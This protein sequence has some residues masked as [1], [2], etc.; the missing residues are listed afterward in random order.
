MGAGARGAEGMSDEVLQRCTTC[1]A[2]LTLDHLRGT[3][4]PYCKTVFPHHARAVEHAA[5][6]G[7]IM[8]QQ[9][10]QQPMLQQQA[11]ANVFGPGVAASF[12]AP[13]APGPFPGGAPLPPPGG[14]G[15]GVSPPPY[16]PPLTGAGGS[17]RPLNTV[18]LVVI[19]GV[20]A[21]VAALLIVAVAVLFL[22]V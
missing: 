9:L 10:A 7:Q 17:S 8:N 6:V 16:V 13:P 5:L 20:V 15:Y 11:M 14:Y 18:G 12:G 1:G 21:T 2:G 22:V 19:V 4:C 3:G